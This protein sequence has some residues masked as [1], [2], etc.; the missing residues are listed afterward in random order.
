MPT[1]LPLLQHTGQFVLSFYFM[2]SSSTSSIIPYIPKILK[3]M[4]VKSNTYFSAYR[5]LMNYIQSEDSS[6]LESSV[7]SVSNV[8]THFKGL[9]CFTFRTKQST[10]LALPDPKDDGTKIL[11]RVENDLPNTTITFHKTR[12][13][14]NTTKKASN[15]AFGMFSSV[16]T[17]Q[18]S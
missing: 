13:S 16:L 4:Y 12:I 3:C 6:L 15:K 10:F 17:N 5:V 1:T 11:R 8:A 2:Q 14:G 7:A 18:V 9:Q